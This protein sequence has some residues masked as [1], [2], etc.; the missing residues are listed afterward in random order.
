MATD[1]TRP[2]DPMASVEDAA[3]TRA[4]VHDRRGVSRGALPRQTQAWIMVGLACL[5]LAV[6]VLTGQPEPSP[7]LS[8]AAPVAPPA[9]VQP[10]RVRSYQ[11]SLTEREARLRALQ[12]TPPTDALV[13]TPLQPVAPS[14]PVDPLVDERRRRD[15]QSL[16]A[17]NVA[18]TRR[19]SAT[20][21]AGAPTQGPAPWSYPGLIPVPVPTAP[22]APTS[23]DREAATPTNA[24]S[25]MPEP[26]TAPAP[27]PTV[28]TASTPPTLPGPQYTL[29]EGT[30]IESVLINR[31]DGTFQGPVQCL[32]TTPVYSHDRQAVVIPA[33]SRVLG[34]AAAVQAWGDRRLAVRF[35]R[36]LLPDGRTV[37][38]ESF[39]GLNQI[40]ETG[41]TDE[42]DRH[43]LQVFG[44]SLAIGA[45]SGLAQFGTRAGYDI[46]AIDASRQAAGTSL[47]T[48]TA[49]VLDRY[50]N[51][52][53][54]VTIREGHRIKIVL[55]NDL[56]LPPY[57]RTTA[58]GSPPPA[59]LSFV[60][61]PRTS[62]GSR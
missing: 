8:V 50:L 61:R 3:G 21:P 15:E 48:S 23:S 6:I 25:T 55:T 51:V 58:A 14:T 4:A 34:S 57:P 37:S 32:V 1:P 18:F 53:P 36:L 35:H 42:V 59:A 28:S 39:T 38:L 9:T 26:A 27:S 54:T 12:A 24:S 13:A 40:G 22:G 20:P 33:G 17:D 46:T 30:L 7:P 56:H 29:L 49:R 62:G 44:A 47:A 11:E 31:L 5:I 45:I 43:Y 10:E 19:G 16:F 2:E 60:S 52:L 41:L